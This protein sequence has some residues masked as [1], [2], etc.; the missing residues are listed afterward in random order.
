MNILDFFN[1]E[2]LWPYVY[3]GIDIPRNDYIDFYRAARDFGNLCA[4]TSLQKATSNPKE[5]PLDYEFV[6]IFTGITKAIIA[7]IEM[8]QINRMSM[9]NLKVIAKYIGPSFIDRKR[10][11]TGLDVVLSGNIEN[12]YVYDT[13][14]VDEERRK[15][16]IG[17]FA[18]SLKAL[19]DCYGITEIK[20]I[21]NVSYE[22]LDNYKR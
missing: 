5:R 16:I 15:R 4:L 13:H 6:D 11:E 2:Y 9:T 3:R 17:A 1:A 22:K 18:G 19:I 10:Y 14:V 8:G 20:N 21:T 12:V 7:T